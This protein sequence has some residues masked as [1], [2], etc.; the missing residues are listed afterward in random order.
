MLYEEHQ[1]SWIR[2]SHFA[3]PRWECPYCQSASLDFVDGS[4]VTHVDPDGL[5]HEHSSDYHPNEYEYV[6][7]AFLRCVN[8]S[9]R[10]IVSCHGAAYVFNAGDGEIV[11]YEKSFAPRHFH[12]SINY[13]RLSEKYPEAVR[14]NLQR[15]F[16]AYWGDLSASLNCLRTAVEA[17]LDNQKIRA[18]SEKGGRIN[19]NQRIDAYVERNKDSRNADLFHALR[20]LGNDGS[21]CTDDKIEDCFVLH[22][23]DMTE[24][25]LKSLYDDRDERSRLFAKVIVSTQRGRKQGTVESPTRDK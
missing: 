3:W 12:P 13:F 4:L 18:F 24:V 10:G 15:S 16:S 8:R 14:R 22:A 23:F 11:C 21:H 5:K 25:L 7:H 9:C 1:E 6:F 19:L 17:I 2:N 20:I